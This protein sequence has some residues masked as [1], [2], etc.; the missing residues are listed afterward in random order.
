MTAAARPMTDDY[1]SRML[2]RYFRHGIAPELREPEA[3]DVEDA[4]FLRMHWAFSPAV[5]ELATYLTDHPHEAQSSQQYRERVDD[6]V[7]RG[8]LLA[9]R[10]LLLRTLTGHPSVVVCDEPVKTFTEGPNHLLLWVLQHAYMILSR[11]RQAVPEP[12]TYGGRIRDAHAAVAKARR[13]NV[14][15]EQSDRT[16]VRVRP[17]VNA[18]V[19]AGR[20]RRPLYRRA[21]AAYE[22]LQQVETGSPQAI[23]SLLMD[24]LIGPLE[25]WQKFELVVICSMASALARRTGEPLMLLPIIAG[26]GK[27]VARVGRFDIY[28]QSTTPHYQRPAPE[29]SESKVATILAAYG[30]GV[31]SDRPDVVVVD[32]SIGRVVAIGEAKY[33][34]DEV[35]PRAD[36]FRAAVEQLV[37]YSRGYQDPDRVLGSSLAAVVVLPERIR[38]AAVADD[39]PLAASLDDLLADRLDTWAQ[40]TL[41]TSQ[42]LAG[43][44]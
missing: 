3:D 15:G 1:L 35:S 4:D 33:L 8:R 44:N 22:L 34:T 10:T 16:G 28:W 32:R 41:R 11:A 17:S 13:I 42:A 36:T 37:R 30:V 23:A 25:N 2:L 21:Y 40:R 31:G 7:I 20:S 12:S 39:I 29:P 19:Q 27:P 38:S 26:S 9:S 43:A 24:T 6:A 14:I 5:V 18:V